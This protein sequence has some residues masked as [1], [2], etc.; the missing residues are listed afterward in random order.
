MSIDLELLGI[1]QEELQQRVVERI[2]N[3]LIVAQRETYDED[4][5]PVTLRNPSQF[6][7]AVMGMLKE[8]IDE[9]VAAIADREV[10]PKVGALIENFVIQKTNSYG[11]KRGE[12]VTFIEYLT[13][14]AD[15]YLRETVDSDGHTKDE[16]RGSYYGGKTTRI[17]FMIDK[18]LHYHINAAMTKALETANSAIVGGIEQ[19]VKMKLDE[20][21]KGIKASVKV[22]S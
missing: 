20:I 21:Q 8:K 13:S 4:G 5:E 15:E 3:A 10:M 11:E 14:R 2:A 7:H 16:A 9:T 22:A 12:P 6:Q 1:T 19:A 17:A 18:H